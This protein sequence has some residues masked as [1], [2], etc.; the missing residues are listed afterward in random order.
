MYVWIWEGWLYVVKVID[1]YK[2]V[3]MGYALDENMCADL[4]IDELQMAS[5]NYTLDDDAIF[6]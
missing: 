3:C 4:V 5:R 1:C 6:H 2:K